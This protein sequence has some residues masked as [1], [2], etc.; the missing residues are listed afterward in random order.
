MD[1]LACHP[2]HSRVRVLTHIKKL[3]DALEALQVLEIRPHAFAGSTTRKD[4]DA[5]AEHHE[6][7]G[8]R[9]EGLQSAIIAAEKLKLVV[10]DAE[11]AVVGLNNIEAQMTELAKAARRALGQQ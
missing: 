1:A 7:I 10:L 11:Q 8:L 6:Q 4:L 5:T 9:M 3:D 2:H